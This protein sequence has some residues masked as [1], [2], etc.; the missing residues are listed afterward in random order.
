M[1]KETN[2]MDPK[3]KTVKWKVLYTSTTTDDDTNRWI[4]DRVRGSLFRRDSRR[5]MVL[6]GTEMAHKHFRIASSETNP[7]EFHK[8]QSSEVNTFPNRQH[9]S[10]RRSIK[11]GR[12]DQEQKNN[13][14]KQGNMGM[15]TLKRRHNY[16]Q[17]AS[18]CD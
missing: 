17:I 1:Q 15:L 4:I 11:N 8:G 9:S 6:P 16:S 3:V 7:I 10:T 14:I 12:R 2:S 5:N 18:E 13:R